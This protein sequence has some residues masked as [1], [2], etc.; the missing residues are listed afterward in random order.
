MESGE[1]TREMFKHVPTENLYTIT[2]NLVDIPVG[3]NPSD[4]PGIQRK[5]VK[6]LNDRLARNTANITI[7]AG[8]EIVHSAYTWIYMLCVTVVSIGD[9]HQESISTTVSW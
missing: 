4:F 1:K 9:S 5:A 7:I 2:I 3:T 8:K 6:N